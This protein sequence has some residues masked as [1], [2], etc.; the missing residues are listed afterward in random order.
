MGANDVPALKDAIEVTLG[1]IPSLKEFR[2]TVGGFP[3]Q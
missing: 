2:Y 1:D 3:I